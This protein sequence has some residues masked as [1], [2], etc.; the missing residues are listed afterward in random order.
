MIFKA[1]KDIP[2][3]NISFYF[4]VIYLGDGLY[5]NV[6]QIYSA[7]EKKPGTGTVSHF[8]R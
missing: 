8:P 4:T 6:G 1:R 3:K 7:P 5:N 2:I